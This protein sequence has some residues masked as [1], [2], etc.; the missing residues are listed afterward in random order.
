[1]G[2]GCTVQSV[3]WGSIFAAG[4]GSILGSLLAIF[5]TPLLQ[6]YFWKRQRRAEI[7][8]KAIET[9][10]TFTSKF[11]QQWISANGAGQQYHP[12]LEWFENFSAAEA[13]VRALFEPETYEAFKNLE[14]RVDPELGTNIS[15]QILNANA[16]IEAR[17]KAM[18]A[19]Y[20]EVI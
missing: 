4:L 15:N 10:T 17:D 7:K 1:V 9:I 13:V 20:S 14:K 12:T 8:L 18:K 2:G 5:A 6:H 19:L 3:N 11:I 16:F